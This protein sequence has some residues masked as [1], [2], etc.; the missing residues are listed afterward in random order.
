M[1]SFP[2]SIHRLL[3]TALLGLSMPA[4]QAQQ[5]QAAKAGPEKTSGP[6]LPQQRN[7]AAPADDQPAGGGTAVAA[8]LP[9]IPPRPESHLLD[10]SGMLS[11]EASK[12]LSARL[13]S[14]QTR[15]GL[16]FYVS[17]HTYLS[18]ETAEDRA[19][20]THDE[21]VGVAGAGIVVV[22]DRS[23]GRI[24]FAGSDDKRLP[25]RESLK[26]LFRLADASAKSLPAQATLPDRLIATV[27]GLAEGLES[28]QK[29]GRLP[30]PPPIQ[31]NPAPQ[32]PSV[33]S[34]TPIMA[35]PESMLLDRAGVFSEQA[36]ATLREQ[37]SLWRKQ[38][39]LQIYVVTVTYPPGNIGIPLADKL[40]L[41]WLSSEPGGVIVFDR[42]LPDSLTIGH[43][44]FLYQWLPPAQLKVVRK[45][46]A[47]DEPAGGRKHEDRI[48]AAAAALM[49]VYVPDGLPI[50]RDG[51][52]LFSPGRRKIFF[53]I[54]IGL[55]LFGTILYLLKRWQ[56]NADLRRRTSFRFPEVYV[57]IRLG[58][59]H[60]G[61]VSVES[62]PVPT[63]PP[64][65][66]TPSR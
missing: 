64:N 17:I 20:R 1:T 10:E 35:R 25:D 38:H 23:T 7:P 16:G 28:W 14:S 48:A 34:A 63:R 45:N 66:S 46:P 18:D 5:K 12:A 55:I 21:W 44:P 49:K 33:P 43:S 31:V 32:G 2:R 6:A 15:T 39:S 61:G 40:A 37:L 58:A 24:G 9:P 51:H 57:P 3:L 53:L 27:T 22:H 29:N 50:W 56:Q 13:L 41:D 59:P 26:G 36:A 62:P 65:A 47:D 54:M 60:G 52:Q 4:V 8:N 11:E 42:S 19:D 30:T